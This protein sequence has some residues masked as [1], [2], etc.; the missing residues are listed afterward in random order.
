MLDKKLIEV[1]RSRYN[2]PIIVIKKKD[3]KW[4]PCVDL[5]GINKATVEDQFSLR[6]IQS[7]IDEIGRNQSK[8]FSSMDMSKGYFQQNL[9]EDSRPYT[10]FTV[11]GLGSYQFKVSCFGSHGAP[12]SF[13]YLINELLRGAKNLIS[14]MDDILAHTQSHDEHLKTLEECFQKVEGL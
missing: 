8:I 7:C 12:A 1:S 2:S 9:E 4:R 11:P 14:Y 5:R 3:G 6:D 13:S 10:S